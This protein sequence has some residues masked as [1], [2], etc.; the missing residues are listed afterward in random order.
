MAKRNIRHEREKRQTGDRKNGCGG[1]CA[2][3]AGADRRRSSHA[4]AGH[5]R[6]ADQNDGSHDGRLGGATQIAEPD[7]RLAVGDVVQAEILPQLQCERKLAKPR[8]FPEGR[9]E[10]LADVGANGGAVAEILG[11]HLEQ[12]NQA[13]LTRDCSVAPTTSLLCAALPNDRVSARRAFHCRAAARAFRRGLSFSLNVR[14]SGASSERC[15]FSSPRPVNTRAI[16][17]KIL[18]VRCAVEISAIIWP[19]LAAVPKMR[20]SKGR[21]ATGWLSIAL[22]NSFTDISGRFGRP[23]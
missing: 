22:A 10:P 3:M 6:N 23:I 19:L 4:I 2:W 14:S 7:D 18:V 21:A 5:R 13:S 20:E 16:C 12:D 9:D 15:D 1:R 8:R 17:R 11:R